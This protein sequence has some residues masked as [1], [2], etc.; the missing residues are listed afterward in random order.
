MEKIQSWLGIDCK[1]FN[2]TNDELSVVA[3]LIYLREQN[4]AGIR[5]NLSSIS[6]ISCH[7]RKDK[8]RS[9]PAWAWA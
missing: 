4:W 9:G 8:D 5:T 6:Y 1:D 2:E 3:T 7:C